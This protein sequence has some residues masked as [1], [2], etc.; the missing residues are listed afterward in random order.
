[1]RLYQFAI[2]HFCEKARW[3]LAYKGASDVEPVYLVPGPHMFVVKRMA[4]RTT[5]PILEDGGQTIQGSNEI[6]NHLE[7]KFPEKRLLP[8]DPALVEAVHEWVRLADVMGEDVRAVLYGEALEGNP[9]EVKRLWTQGAPFIQRM[10]IKVM[11]PVVVKKI[12]RYYRLNATDLP[13]FEARFEESLARFD[14]AYSKG[15]YLV[16]DRFSWADMSV[17]AILAS[18]V[19]PPQH[20]LRVGRFTDKTEAFLEKHR[21]SKT[22]QRVKELYADYR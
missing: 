8:D 14:E 19:N 5:V 2:S 13:R 10:M 20:P 17:A 12:K 3:A 21:N 15:P 11:Y 18:M 7:V 4:K 22:L 9:K 6:L 16:G 1:M